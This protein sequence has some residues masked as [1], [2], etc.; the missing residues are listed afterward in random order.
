MENGGRVSCSI[1]HLKPQASTTS[2]H[3]STRRECQKFNQIL[4]SGIFTPI[5]TWGF[6]ELNWRHNFPGGKIWKISRINHGSVFW[7]VRDSTLKCQMLKITCHMPMPLYFLILHYF[8]LYRR[9]RCVCP[10]HQACARLHLYQVI[11]CPWNQVC[12]YSLH[13][14]AYVLKWQIFKNVFCFWNCA[15]TC[16]QAH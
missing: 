13:F 1:H 8:S 5:D 6:S 11:I 10:W 2:S 14:K 9:A 3:D 12:P 4:I 16:L 7:D 15:C